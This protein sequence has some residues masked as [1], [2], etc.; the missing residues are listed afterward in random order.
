MAPRVS[1]FRTD[2]A[3]ATMRRLIDEPPQALA[4]LNPELPPW[5][6]AIVERLLEKDASR[7]FSS[8]KEVSELLEGCLAHVQ[9]PA[10]VPLPAGVPVVKSVAPALRQALRWS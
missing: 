9:Q 4:S 6:I 5:F 7:R 1:P 3:L 10:K 2:S 8:A